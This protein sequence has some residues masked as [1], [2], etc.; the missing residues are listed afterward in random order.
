MRV[1]IAVACLEGALCP[2]STD[3]KS[4]LQLRPFPGVGY[5]RFAD[6]VEVHITKCTLRAAC[7]G[8]PGEKETYCTPGYRGGLCGDCEKG[9]FKDGLMG[10]VCDVALTMRSP[11]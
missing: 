6:E 3:V 1:V 4:G 11:T 7:Q 9:Y 2:G 5:Y 10:V 8:G